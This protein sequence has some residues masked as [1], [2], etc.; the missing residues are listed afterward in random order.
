MI[1]TARLGTALPATNLWRVYL[2]VQALPNDPDGCAERYQAV[3][4]GHIF[5]VHAHAAVAGVGSDMRPLGFLSNLIM[6]KLGV[7]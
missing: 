6:P 7:A 5:V 3:E 1:E 4:I 2:C